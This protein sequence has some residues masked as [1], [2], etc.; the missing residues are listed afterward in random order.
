MDCK[1][2]FNKGCCA[3]MDIQ[4]R[5]S[6]REDFQFLVKLETASF[7]A[8]QRSKNKSLKHSLHSDFQEVSIIETNEV[9]IGALVLF[10][11]SKSLRI[12]SIAIM[13][14]FQNKGFGDYLLKYVFEEARQ[15]Q[16]EKVLIEVS[17]ENIKLVD[18]YRNRGFKIIAKIDDYYGEGV[19]ALK[20]EYDIHSAMAA[21]KTNNIIVINQPNKWDFPDTNV[22]V[23][24]VKE[25]IN[26]SIYQSSAD[27][28]V[29]NLCSSYKYQSYGYY[30]SLLASARGQR[31]IPSNI[32]IR[33]FRILNVIHSVAFDIDE[34]INKALHK[35]AGGTFVLNVY[36]G[37]TNIKGFSFLANKLYQLFE[38]PLFKV[39]FV[40]TGKW[41]IKKIE[42]LTLNKVP[43]ADVK[44]IYEFAKLYFNK[45]RFPYTKLVNYKYDVAILVN[46]EESTP[47]S[48]AKALQKFKNAANRKGLYVEFITKADFNKINEFDALFIRE[49]TNVNNHTYEFSR[50][51][52]A[53]GLVVID[54]PWS[55]LK[56][57]NKIY[58][59]EI[60]KKHKILTPSTIIFTKNM[61]N[62]SELNHMNF[63]L[64]LKQPD[65]A[66][67][68]GITKVE[69]A[70]EAWVELNC[71][72]KKSDMVVCQEYMYSDFDW[73][74]GIMDNKPLFACKYYMSKGHWQIYNWK[75]GAEDYSG[76]FETMSI[77]RVPEIVVQTAIK[78]A[79]LIGDGLYGVDLKMIDDKVYVVEVNDNPNIDADI[80]DYELKDK[81]YDLI[82]ESI[83]QRIE[84]AKNIQKIDFRR[85]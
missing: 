5:K 36:F 42:V 67:S 48:C 75:S 30:V 7:P 23:I 2:G 4:I 26:N 62:R 3:G 16:Y 21:A 12:Y 83:Y 20:M 69:N 46:P 66:F 32:T 22:K 6:T 31:A 1:S 47:P 77:D 56:C 50:M 10:K 34:I 45:K 82:I 85:S 78:A 19:D 24:S 51:A 44:Y 13:P 39:S 52:Y 49:T 25:Y 84:I 41:I 28:R 72:F 79:A 11:Y 71:L 68:L 17:A 55:I 38:A 53:E 65:S 27:F 18:W 14:G 40:N 60:F 33:D 73:R 81:L 80:E 29:F 15:H 63:P 70:D 43:E 57:S 59:N 54:D 74:I 64:V 76:N 37:Q 58:Q 35:I 61:F 9:P 8:I